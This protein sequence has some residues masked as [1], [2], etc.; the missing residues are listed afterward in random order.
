MHPAEGF[1]IEQQ[2]L[3][4]ARRRLRR[5]ELTLQRSV[6]F[7]QLIEKVWTDREQVAPGQPHDLIQVAE[8]CAHNLRLVAEFLVVVVNACNGGDAR[9]LVRGD[10]R[11]TAL[12][13]MPI[14]NS[15]DERRNQSYSSLRARD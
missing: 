2:P 14:V 12:L 9:I 4:R 1:F 15:S 8:A 5:I 10:L 13:F 7:L 3:L 11:S 6:R